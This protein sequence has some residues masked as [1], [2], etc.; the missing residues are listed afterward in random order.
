MHC[1]DSTCHTIRDIQRKGEKEKGKGKG[2]GKWEGR[3]GRRVAFLASSSWRA[4]NLFGACS[5]PGAVQM[6]VKFVT[7]MNL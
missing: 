4:T 5:L 2:K 3:A 6:F 7:I 1:K